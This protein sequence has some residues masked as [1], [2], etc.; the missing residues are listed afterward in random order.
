MRNKTL[1]SYI[2]IAVLTVLGLALVFSIALYTLPQ[3]NPATLFVG[4]TFHLP[5]AE[6][7]GYRVDL[8]EF[9]NDVDTIRFLESSD[10]TFT[11]QQLKAR[12]WSHI[13]EEYAT[14]KLAV[15]Q[16][17]SWSDADIITFLNDFLTTNELTAGDLSSSIPGFNM[18]Y[19]KQHIILPMLLQEKVAKKLLLAADNDAAKE[20]NALHAQVAQDPSGFQALLKKRADDEH[21]PYVDEPIL[22]SAQEITADEATLLRS[23]SVGGI[24]PVIVR[25]DGYRIY[26]LVSHFTQPQEAWQVRELFVPASLMDD[27]LKK[28]TDTPDEKIY[29]RGIL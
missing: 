15:Q 16:S 7:Y 29:I 3:Q 27:A 2:R 1:Y 18:E 24:T 25:T 4:Q 20:I 10:T 9:L 14:R 22:I 23:L 5:F 6:V 26:Q 21:V 12:V 8:S 13:Q 17:I 28:L 19:F 11:P